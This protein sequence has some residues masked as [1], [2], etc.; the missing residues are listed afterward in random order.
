MLLTVGGVFWPYG[1]V[2]LEIARQTTFRGLVLIGSCQSF[3]AVSG[4]LRP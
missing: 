2:A 4:L 3:D 1:M